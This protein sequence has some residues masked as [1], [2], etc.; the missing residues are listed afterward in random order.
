MIE[1]ILSNAL[2]DVNAMYTILA[3]PE[4]KTLPFILS[5]TTEFAVLGQW[6]H[7]TDRDQLLGIISSGIPYTGRT[8]MLHDMTRRRDSISISCGGLHKKRICACTQ[9]I[10][11][12]LILVEQMG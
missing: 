6:Q 5:Q 7:L 4:K 11:F 2:N 9:N 8:L 1:I 10:T 3:L 12:L